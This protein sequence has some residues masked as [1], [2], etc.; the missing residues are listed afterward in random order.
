MRILYLVK[1]IEALSTVS[2]IKTAHKL[3]GAMQVQDIATI[4]W[5]GKLRLNNNVKL[6]HILFGL[7]YSI[8]LIVPNKH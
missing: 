4:D 3:S 7:P 8:N 1:V 6:T 5:P 2:Q